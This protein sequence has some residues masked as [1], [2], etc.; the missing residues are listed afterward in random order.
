MRT[1][2]GRLNPGRGVAGVSGLRSLGAVVHGDTA[3]GH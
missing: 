2:A 3:P 1:N